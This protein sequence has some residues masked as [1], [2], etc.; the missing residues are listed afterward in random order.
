VALYINS[1]YYINAITM[2]IISH[3]GNLLGPSSCEENTVVAIHA[4]IGAG[5]AVEIDAWS[6]GAEWWLGHDGPEHLLSDQEFAGL[7]SQPNILWHAKNAHAL[8][9]LRKLGMHCFWHEDDLFTVTSN[10]SILARVGNTEWEGCIAVMPERN[11]GD[12]AWPTGCVGIMTD[13]PFAYRERAGKMLPTMTCI[14]PMA[15]K[16]ERFSAQGFTLPKFMLPVDRDGTTM[17]QAAT[18]SLGLPTS[19]HLVFIVQAEHLITYVDLKSHLQSLGKE[20]AKATIVEINAVLNGPACSVLTAMHAIDPTI[21]L[22]VSNCDQILE[23][24]SAEFLSQCTKFDGCVLTFFPPDIGAVGSADKRSF[25]GFSGDGGRVVEFAE[26][27]VLSSEALVGVHY[28]KSGALFEKAA[29]DMI[30]AECCAPNGEFYLSLTYNFMLAEALTIGTHALAN[31]EKFWCVGAADDYFLYWEQSQGQKIKLARLCDMKSGWLIGD[32]N[33]CVHRTSEF[34][35]GV[36]THKA[37][38]K[39]PIHFHKEATEINVLLNGEMCMNGLTISS[40]DVFVFNPGEIAAP[41]FT[42]DCTV[43][44]IKIPSRPGDKFIL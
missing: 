23:Y 19:T 40:N 15:G 3:R 12:I 31:K 6:I 22:I 21:P 20:Y 38:E 43:L 27:I 42:R 5:F 39:W 7:Q 10:G 34:E 30:A 17:I 37:G 26:K 25:V 13:Y 4:A 18:R 8:G 11:N 32:F 16:G 44:C 9:S 24:N 35:V 14:I 41:K 2:L 28:Y 33:P 29:N 36:L 1:C